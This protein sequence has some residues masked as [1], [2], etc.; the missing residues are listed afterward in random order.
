[1]NWPGS[2]HVALEFYNI[3]SGGNDEQIRNL[4]A[5]LGY[6]KLDGI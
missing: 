4:G 2:Q 3:L 6:P 1:V 5:E